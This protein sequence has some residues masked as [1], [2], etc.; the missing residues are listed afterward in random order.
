MIHS[1]SNCWGPFFPQA[2]GRHQICSSGQGR[3]APTTC[4]TRKV[5]RALQG[6]E[7]HPLSKRCVTAADSQVG[8]ISSPAIL[9][10]TVLWCYFSMNT[11]IASCLFYQVQEEQTRLFH[12]DIYWWFSDDLHYISVRLSWANS[13]KIATLY[14][15]WRICL[16]EIL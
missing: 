11:N 2:A 14:P 4:M 8:L 12:L 16:F 10:E 6:R 13:I 15:L 5:I 7:A 1:F 3:H 9:K